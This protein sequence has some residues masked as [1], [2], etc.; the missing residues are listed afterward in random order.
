VPAELSPARWKRVRR[1]QA[2]P[3]WFAVHAP[4]G[5]PAGDYTTAITMTAKGMADPVRLDLTVRVW[6]YELPKKWN[7]CVVGSF[8]AGGVRR[9]YGKDFKAEWMDRWYDFLLDRRVAPVG[10]YSR[11]L[12]PPVERIRHCVD[13]G[14]NAI[15]LHGSFKRNS[16]LNVIRQRH[17][18]LKEMGVIDKAIIYVEDEGHRHA[19]RQHLALNVRK[20]AP[21][22]MMMVGGG[23]PNPQGI[24]YIDVWDPAIGVWP[25]TKLTAAEARKVVEAC[26]QR[27]EKFFWYVAAGP[28]APYPN[29]QLEYPLIGARAY[30][31]MSW[32]YRATGFEYYCY[33]IWNHNFKSP[34]RWPE[35]PWDARA[36]VSRNSAYNC[37]GMLFYPGPAGTPCPSIRLENI[38]DG[39]EDWESFHMLRDYA[40]ALRAKGGHDELLK[41]ADTMVDVPDEVV[42]SVTQWSQDPEL[43]LKTRRKLA[44]LIVAIKGLVSRGEYEKVRDAR[45]AAQ[46]RREREMLKKRASTPAPQPPDAKPG[47]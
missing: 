29:V 11:A 36:F 13:R 41:Q 37:D 42:K 32:K 14:M 9:F 44:G 18:K 21:E 39:I 46:L 43:L 3:F 10:Q 6:D 38:R 23:A 31:W 17:A 35:V 1:Q 45:Q 26:Q 40:D 8:G 25:G 34:K 47:K 24:G 30:I 19:M 4:P 12:T 28:T 27:G 2:T 33:N 20:A 5:T 22:A 16:D 7:F 15:Y